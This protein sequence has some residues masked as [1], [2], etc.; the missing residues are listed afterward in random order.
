M[1]DF[2]CPMGAA[3]YDDEPCIECELCLATTKEEMIEA[4]KKIREYLRSHAERNSTSKKIA[5]CGKGGTGKSTVV[6]LMGNVLRED[7]YTVLVIDTDESN[8]GLYRMFGFKKQPTPLMMLLDRFSAGEVKAE[9]EWLT[10]EEILIQD[11]PSGYVLEDD[12]LKFLMAGKIDDPFQ[13]CACSMADVTR[14]LVRKLPVKDREVMLIDMEAGIES[15][16]RGVERSVDTVLMVIEPSFES[17]ALAE[18]ICYMAQGIG[19]NRVRA[20]LNKIPSER[21]E[22]KI[23]E[24]LK[25]KGIKSIGTIYYDAQVS[26]AGFEGRVLGDSKAKQEVWRIT[27]RL[28]DES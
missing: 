1:G 18:K 9:A 6:T 25:K 3:F 16:G 13:G 10:Q 15:F 24:E 20:I 26:E 8:P 12:N 11:I 5:V 19:V 27:R 17:L 7:G 4:S 28:F 2:H 22:V 14:E 21:V 23:I